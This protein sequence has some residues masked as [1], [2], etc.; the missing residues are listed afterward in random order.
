MRLRRISV[1]WA[2]LLVGCAERDNPYDPVNNPLVRQVVDTIRRPVPGLFNRVL[3]PESLDRTCTG[4][5]YYAN[6]HTALAEMESGDTLWIPGGDRYFTIDRSLTLRAGGSERNPVVI[7]S[8]G[9]KA[10]IRLV[11]K[12]GIPATFC[13]EITQPFVRIEGITFIN[14][15]TS[16]FAADINGPLVLDSVQFVKS[17][18]ALDLQRIKGRTKLHHVLMTGTV[19]NPPF[20]FTKLDSLDTFDFDWTP[21][22][23]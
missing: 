1:G 18:I 15:E 22:T 13:L 3:L 10:T 5:C 17:E 2:L 12:E 20:L 19:Q 4:Y 6:I 21:R 23:N 8:Y 11:P 14:C 16:I 9:G 7:R